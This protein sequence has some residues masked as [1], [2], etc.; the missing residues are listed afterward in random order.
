MA[1]VTQLGYLGLGVKDGDAWKQFATNVLGFQV[2]TGD[3]QGTFYLRMDEYHHRFLIHPGDDDLAYIG[4]EVPDAQTLQAVAAR[5]EAAGVHVLPGRRDEVDTRRV[6]D[7]IKFEDPSGIPT[8]IYYG[9][10][11]SE[12]PFQ[13]TRPITGF[14]TGPLGLGHLVVYQRDLGKSIAFYRD[15]LGLRLSDFVHLTTPQG[16]LTAVF[17]HCNPRH[18]SIAFIETPPLPKRINHFMVELN[19]LDDVGL[20]RDVCLQRGVPIP[21]DLGKHTNDRMVSFY[22]SNPSDFMVEYGWGG[23]SVDDSTWQV[24]HWTSGSIWGHPG[25]NDIAA[26]S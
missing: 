17:F 11:L 5:L 23:R 19:A 16:K 9:P 18:H 1:N 10:Y 2:T 13:P 26:K 6:L 7:C 12:R 25:L 20:G 14:R 24:Q 4:W 22:M 15:V 3:D 8:E 21:I